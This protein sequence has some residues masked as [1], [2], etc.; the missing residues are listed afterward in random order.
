MNKRIIHKKCGAFD[1]CFYAFNQF[2]GLYFHS[3][4]DA[5]RSQRS[6][7]LVARI[8][9]VNKLIF[10]EKCGGFGERFYAF[11]GFG[12]L[13]FRASR[14]T[15]RSIILSFNLLS[16]I[17]SCLYRYLFVILSIVGKLIF[18]SL[19]SVCKLTHQLV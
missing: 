13:Y 3:S 4:K 12:E 19:L 5:P 11:N 7:Q 2:S 8:K 18:Y 10:F 14:C 15:L 16:T 9:G 1:G 6:V 17:S